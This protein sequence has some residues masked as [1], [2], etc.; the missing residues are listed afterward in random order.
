VEPP[1][2]CKGD[3]VVSRNNIFLAVARL[4]LEDASVA[5]EILKDE[6]WKENEN[7]GTMLWKDPGPLLSQ[8]CG[9]RGSFKG[10]H[11][12]RWDLFQQQM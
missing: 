1:I 2:T 8:W 9:S 11:G 6:D 12:E 5:S 10:S 4:K 7:A 3:L